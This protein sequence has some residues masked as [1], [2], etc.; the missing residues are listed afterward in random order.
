[1]VVIQRSGW[2]WMAA[3]GRNPS[4]ICP[5]PYALLSLPRY[6]F[7]KDSLFL[8]NDVSLDGHCSVFFLFSVFLA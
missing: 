4:E 1:M 3:G 6:I 8:E 2:R 7:L 5:L